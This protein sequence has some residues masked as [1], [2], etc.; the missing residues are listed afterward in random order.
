MNPTH[1]KDAGELA[2]TP[3]D[4][5]EDAAPAAQAPEVESEQEE[6]SSV[7]LYRNTVAQTWEHATPEAAADADDRHELSADDD[8][9]EP[10]E[11]GGWT[12]ALVCAGVA[13][14]AVC[15]LLPLAEENH[16]LAYQREKLKADLDQI[17][18]QVDVNGEFLTKVTD[19]PTLA[20]R[21][22]E[23]QM[24]FVREGTSVLD[25]PDSGKEGMSPFLLTAL[26]P[27]N[28]MPPYHPLGGA[29]SMFGRDPHLR[30][31]T[32]GAGLLFLAAGT[33]LGGG[34]KQTFEEPTSDE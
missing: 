2:L 13:M 3:F 1:G 4:L 9:E 5:P 30:L 11:K 14:I 28:P 21:L 15:L 26:P 32:L 22:A 24:K 25:I 29:L 8:E 34:S 7:V 10:E 23:R 17:K 18:K 19:D 12:V 6:S 16:Q 31:Y 20:E 33:V 27:P